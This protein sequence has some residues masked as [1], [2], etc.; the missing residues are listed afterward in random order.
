[1]ACASMCTW[2]NITNLKQTPLNRGQQV[3]ALCKGLID[4]IKQN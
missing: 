1:M 3:P 2:V 4:E